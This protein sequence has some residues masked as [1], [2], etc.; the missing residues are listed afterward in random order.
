[1]VNPDFARLATVLRSVNGAG[2]YLFSLDPVSAGSI[3]Y[4]RFFDPIL[5]IAEDAATGT[6]AGPLACQLVAQRIVEDGTTLLI[7]QGH[8]RGGPA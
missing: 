3:V 6:A 1:M 4:T 7:E 2:C 8:A 5:S